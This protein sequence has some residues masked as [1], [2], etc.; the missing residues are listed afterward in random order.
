MIRPA[1]EADIPQI[2]GLLRQVAQVHCDARPDL[3]RGDGA[4]KYGADELRAVITDPQRPVFVFD[5]GG[6]IL[7]HAFCVFQR[8]EGERVMV[9]ATTLYIDDICVDESARHRHVGSA[10]YEHAVRFARDAGC[11]NVTLNVWEG[12]P[13][14]I[15][16][17][18]A[19][20]MHVQKYGMETVLD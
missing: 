14:A 7:G 6:R 13:D 5:D 2:L 15:A 10:L 20:G 1:V 9:D 19:L 17:Y 8:H 18:R 3:F 16:F 12:N 11:H 4:T